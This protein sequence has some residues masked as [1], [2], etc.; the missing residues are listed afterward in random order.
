MRILIA[1]DSFKGSLNATEACAA[2]EA[3]VRIVAPDAEIKSFPISDGGEGF[4]ELLASAIDADPITTQSKKPSGASMTG[5]VYKNRELGIMDIATCS[6]LNLCTPDILNHTTEGS[7]IL[8]TTLINKGCKE[9]IIG[10]GGSATHDLGL[11]ILRALGYLFYDIE[12]KS[13]SPKPS[14]FNSISRI[15]PPDTSF[16]HVAITLATDVRN[17]LLGKEGAAKTF[18]A[19]K[20]ANVDT[21]NKLEGSGHHLA[22]IIASGQED[23]P[24]SGAAGG[25]A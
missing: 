17:L 6:G 10:L 4:S 16:D 22:K 11:G 14:D 2:I 15:N 12:D 5:T 18:A 7:G 3:G 20:G 1:S 21:I 8:L 23:H 24:G 19:Q 9:I 13:I 25:I